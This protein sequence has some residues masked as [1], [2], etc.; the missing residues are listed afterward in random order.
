MSMNAIIVNLGIVLLIIGGILCVIFIRMRYVSG[1]LH[2]A[3]LTKSGRCLSSCG[4]F[5]TGVVLAVAGLGLLIY[6]I[7]NITG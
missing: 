4:S 5:T 1:T 6:R 7:L 2:H 3:T